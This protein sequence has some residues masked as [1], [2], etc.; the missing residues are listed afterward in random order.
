MPRSIWGR[1]LRWLTRCRR[2]L[3]QQTPERV[4]L[5]WVLLTMVWSRAYRPARRI[6]AAV[7][8]D[9]ELYARYVA[10]PRDVL[11]QSIDG[12]LA[13]G[14]SMGEEILRS[15][16]ARRR[17]GRRGARTN[18]LVEASHLAYKART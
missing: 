8:T 5:S 4:W 3:Q 10:H 18:L 7:A 16:E 14:G 17:V 12:G 15:L 11:L 13:V 9:T 6:V 2:W 1:F